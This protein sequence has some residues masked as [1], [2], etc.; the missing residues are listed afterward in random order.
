MFVQKSGEKH[1]H[2]TRRAYKTI[3]WRNGEKRYIL[4]W[5]CVLPGC[6]YKVAYDLVAEKPE[7]N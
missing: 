7:G 4:F 2:K 1:K 3:T 6:S 5:V